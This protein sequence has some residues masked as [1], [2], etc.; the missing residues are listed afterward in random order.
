ML[1][2]LYLFFIYSYFLD[3]PNTYGQKVYSEGMHAGMCIILISAIE[4]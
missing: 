1:T 3:I 4:Y 2:F